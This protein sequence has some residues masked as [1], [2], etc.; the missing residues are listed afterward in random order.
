MTYAAFFEIVNIITECREVFF[1]IQ[2]REC[3]AHFEK[4]VDTA[5]QRIKES[6]ES[7]GAFLPGFALEEA[8]TAEELNLYIYLRILKDTYENCKRQGIPDEVFIETA[9]GIN[10][11]A[12]GC[13]KRYGMYGV[14]QKVYREWL[15]IIVLGKLY[16]L[17]KRFKFEIRESDCQGNVF[18][19]DLKVGDT[20]KKVIL[21]K[22]ISAKK[23][24]LS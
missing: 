2:K 3:K 15:R 21:T 23:T 24:F 6:D 20:M 18:G 14:P 17:N 9:N 19:Q 22:I 12:I 7:F 11:N 13:K 16:S 5:I 4:N 10:L 1:E 8:L